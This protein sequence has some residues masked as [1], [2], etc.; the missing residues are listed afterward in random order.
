MYGQ[1]GHD[2][3]FGNGAV[4]YLSGGSGNDYLDGGHDELADTL[5]GGGDRDTFVYHVHADP[6]SAWGM[7]LEDNLD[8]IDFSEDTYEWYFW[9]T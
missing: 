8:D 9:N 3:L 4:D 6:N 7:S 5:V 1:G 2:R